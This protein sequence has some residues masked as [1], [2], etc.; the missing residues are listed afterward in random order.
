[1]DAIMSSPALLCRYH[2]SVSV[3]MFATWSW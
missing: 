3:A 1:M 2:Q